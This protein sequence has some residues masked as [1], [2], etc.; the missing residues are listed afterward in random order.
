MKA[1]S[2]N[3]L[4]REMGYNAVSGLYILQHQLVGQMAKVI[5]G[6]MVQEEKG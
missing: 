4:L 3:I 5:Q 6:H 2:I 1:S